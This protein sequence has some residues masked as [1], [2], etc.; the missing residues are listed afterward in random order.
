MI[1]NLEGV[2]GQNGTFTK[3]KGPAKNSGGVQLPTVLAP[4]EVC[5]KHGRMS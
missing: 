3:S 1:N 2:F 5:F 4:I